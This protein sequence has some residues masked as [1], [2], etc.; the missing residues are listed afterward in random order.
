MST[1]SDRELLSQMNG[2]DVMGQVQRYEAV[3][4]PL[5]YIVLSCLTRF[6]PNL[7]AQFMI[8]RLFG[9]LCFATT[10]WITQKIIA[11]LYKH[12][13]RKRDTMR[14]ALK[15]AYNPHALAAGCDHPLK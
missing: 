5:Y 9:L 14:A 11:L 8:M 15:P 3:Q 1:Y 12:V 2:V 6:I 4:V 13:Y 7:Y 10:L